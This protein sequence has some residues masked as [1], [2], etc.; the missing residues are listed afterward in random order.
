MTYRTDGEIACLRMTDD[1]TADRCVRTHGTA[2]GQRD[3]DAFQI[4]KLVDDEVKAHV[5]Q[6]WIA[7]GRTQA[8][9]TS[10]H[11]LRCGFGEAVGEGLG[12]H[13]LVGVVVAEMRQAGTHAGGEQ[14]HGVS[15]GMDE[16]G[17]AEIR[18]AL[19]AEHGQARVADDD[20]VAIGVGGELLY[21]CL[22]HRLVAPRIEHLLGISEE[23]AGNIRPAHL[24]RMVE[25][26]PVDETAHVLYGISLNA[27]NAVALRLG[28]G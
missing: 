21:K 16:V 28:D 23:F 10:V 19:L 25:V 26:A 22:A 20:I 14:A 9:V 27:Q 11:L 6:T 24:P 1:E 7:N 13:A 12:E 4:Y 17:E 3:A 18:L 2:L 8:R 15:L 5:G